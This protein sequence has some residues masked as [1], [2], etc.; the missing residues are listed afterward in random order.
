MAQESALS[1]IAPMAKASSDPAFVN[2]QERRDTIVSE[3][4]LAQ[5]KVDELRKELARV[6]QF[7]RDWRAFAGEIEEEPEFAMTA[8]SPPV[9]KNPDKQLIGDLAEASMVTKG[10]PI[11]RRELMED[12]KKNGV[13]LHGKNPDMILSTMMWRMQDRFVRIPGFGYWFRDEIYTPAKYRPGS[14]PDTRFLSKEQQ[15]EAAVR[16]IEE[17]NSED[18]DENQTPSKAPFVPVNRGL[19]RF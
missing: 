16:D 14:I 8:D 17:D 15:A 5:Q 13:F 10:R 12:L 1:Y 9:G 3:L 11:P 6:D 2:A 4:S 7:L 19:R 18:S